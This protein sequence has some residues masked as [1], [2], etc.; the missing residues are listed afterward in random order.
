M[1]V[2]PP[3]DNEKQRAGRVVPGEPVVLMWIGAGTGAQHGY[4]VVVV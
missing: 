2:A 3:V 1:S 4:A